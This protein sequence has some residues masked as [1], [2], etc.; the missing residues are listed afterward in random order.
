MLRLASILYSL[1]G[2]SLAGTLVIAA[3][4]LGYGTLQPIIAAA[5][6]G[7]VLALPAAWII[8][9]MIIDNN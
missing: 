4:T 6:I 7:F 9:K 8:A 3:L 5:A 1:I 2:T